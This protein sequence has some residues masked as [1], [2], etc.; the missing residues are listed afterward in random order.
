MKSKLKMFAQAIALFIS[1]L[2]LT[3][4][5]LL[6]HLSANVPDFAHFDQFLNRDLRLYFQKAH[7]DLTEVRFELLR[8]VATQ[9]GVAYPKFYAWVKVYKGKQVID[10]GAIRIAAIEKTSFQVTHYLSKEEIKKDPGAIDSVFP[11]LLCPG[12]IERADK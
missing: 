9:S 7:P 4:C 11:A 5:D 8:R 12:I 2:T 6:G 3:S 1:V 10:E